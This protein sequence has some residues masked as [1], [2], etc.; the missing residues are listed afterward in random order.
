MTTILYILAG[1]V[2][3]VIILA[4]IAPK[5]YD[6]S[7][8]IKVQQSVPVVFEYLKYLKNQDNWSPW[9]K[10][11]PN[12]KKEFEGIDGDNR[13]YQQMGRKQGCW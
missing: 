9:G 12:M 13:R 1:I 6:V 2:V 5:N 3:L 11:D 4:L 8:S 10:R 7:R